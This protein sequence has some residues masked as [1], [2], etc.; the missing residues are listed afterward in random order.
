MTYYTPLTILVLFALFILCAL[1][2]ENDRFSK[3][4]KRILYLTYSIVALAAVS[5]WLGVCLNGCTDIS[6]WILRL[7]KLFDYVITPLAGGA[8]VLQFN[9]KT[10]WKKMLFVVLSLNTL[11]QLISFFTGWMITV[12]D[13][14]RYAHGPAYNVYMVFYL[15]VILLVIIECAFYGR[16]FRKQNR[17]SL[18]AILVLAIVGVAFQEILGSEVRTSYIALTVCFALLFIHNSEFTQLESDDKI[19]EQMIRISEDPLTGVFSRYAYTEEVQKYA[20]SDVLPE[21]LVIF[22]IDINGLKRTNDTIGHAAGDE[23]ICGASGVIESALS[24]YGKCFRTGGDE[25]IVIANVSR[26]KAA[27]LVSLLNKK[28]E[29]WRGTKVPSLSLAVGYASAAAEKEKSIDKLIIS[30]DQEMYKEKAEY[31]RKAGIERRKG[32]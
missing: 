1:A 25:F 17:F 4:E 32:V 7:V 16:K 24:K 19:Q 5:E 29:E 21:D 13:S 8:V 6:P 11:F 23:L 10:V 18:F 3:K 9:S 20:S 15:L 22:S 26:E 12:D 14:N 30:A 2:K 27:E 28:A 31:Y